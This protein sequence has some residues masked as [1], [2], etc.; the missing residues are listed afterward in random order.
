MGIF[1]PNQIYLCSLSLRYSPRVLK[2]NE[3]SVARA[4][5]VSRFYS[6]DKDPV[7]TLL[8]G[9]ESLPLV[10]IRRLFTNLP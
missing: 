6:R 8:A 3:A 4:F 9:A 10:S 5:H 7:N 1:G 2:G